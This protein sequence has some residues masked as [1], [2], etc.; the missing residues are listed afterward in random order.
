MTTV[1]RRMTAHPVA[2]PLLAPRFSSDGRSTHAVRT[3][4]SI[5]DSE[6]RV[7]VG[8]VSPAVDAGRLSALGDALV[9]WDPFRTNALHQV[10]L[11]GKFVSL[12]DRI[13]FGGIEMALLDLQGRTLDVPV[14]NL[15]GGHIHD[16][17]PVSG[18]L[19]RGDRGDEPEIETSPEPVVE[20]A[21]Y[22]TSEFGLTIFKFK[23]G[24]VP[25]TDDV[26][27]MRAL[28]ERFPDARLRIDPNGAWTVETTRRALQAM[29]DLDLDWIEDPVLGRSRMGEVTRASAVPTA[30]NMCVTNFEE[31]HDG[32]R[33]SAASII[34][35]DLG[36]A[37]GLRRARAFTHACQ[38]FGLGTAVH[39]GPLNQTGVGLAATLHFSS[40]LPDLIHAVDCI[41]YY[42]SDDVVDWSP[43][44]EQGSLP[45]PS[46]SG[47]GIQLDWDKVSRYET[48]FAAVVG[49]RGRIKTS[50]FGTYPRY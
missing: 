1:I 30:T 46:G 23:A 26:K 18:V 47:L 9:G 27:V 13:L 25:V 45:V 11:G 32:L 4:V 10:L 35:T 37:G 50:P 15:L 3:I 44:Y 6:G 22:L 42:N 34:L 2:I 20:Q 17:I 14:T 8:V 41:E 16:R 19:Y 5:E 43:A 36:Y 28:R 7:G 33:A 29:A 39:C 12:A 31:L 24:A 40:T 49:N 38:S 48:E 21:E